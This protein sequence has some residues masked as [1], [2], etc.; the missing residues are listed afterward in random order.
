M[1]VLWDQFLLAALAQ[2]PEVELGSSRLDS[3]YSLPQLSLSP[4]PK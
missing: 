3:K 1:I 2:V 4:S